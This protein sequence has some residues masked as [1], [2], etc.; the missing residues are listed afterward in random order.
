MATVAFLGMLQKASNV[1]NK[2][3]RQPASPPAR[4]LASTEP[5]HGTGP[6]GRELAEVPSKIAARVLQWV[7]ASSI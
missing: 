3:P 7:G 6:I 4:E 2:R 5:A 1:R